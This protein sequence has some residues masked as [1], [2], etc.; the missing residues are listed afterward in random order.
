VR[1]IIIIDGLDDRDVW[2]RELSRDGELWMLQT[3]QPFARSKWENG[4]RKEYRKIKPRPSFTGIL[5]GSIT[6]L[7]FLLTVFRKAP[8]IDLIVIDHSWGFLGRFLELFPWPCAKWVSYHSDYVPP[9][10]ISL[11]LT[12]WLCRFASWTAD[13]V[14][15]KSSRLPYRTAKGD[16]RIMP[17]SIR[18][19]A[20]GY[21]PQRHKGTKAESKIS[22]PRL[23][24]SAVKNSRSGIFYC[25]GG[26]PHHGLEE[27][28][29]IAWRWGIPVHV[30]GDLSDKFH[31]SKIIEDTPPEQLA[32]ITFYDH[33]YEG[34]LPRIAAKCF[35][36]WAVYTNLDKGHFQHFGFPAKYL[37]Y[38]SLG[39]PILT[40]D[41]SEFSNKI[42]ERRL[43]AIVEPSAI[44][45]EM[46]IQWISSHH[47]QLQEAIIR[48]RDEWNASVEATFRHI[49]NAATEIRRTQRK[50][51]SS[52][53]SVPSVAKK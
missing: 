17:S 15:L 13:E 29:E 40:T 21:E 24:V 23:C 39:L 31:L 22:T 51:N 10:T 48:F 7:W 50:A 12:D 37:Q 11:L 1:T 8:C 28:F 5:H 2:C 35:C 16:F 4:E 46:G 9:R 26:S 38:I 44:Q 20:D 19:V 33:L 27:L 32:N 52:S 49:R 42:E 45:F 34:E 14:W 36:G 6:R 41:V 43:G 3:G 25:S 53:A 30:I 18:Q 47:M